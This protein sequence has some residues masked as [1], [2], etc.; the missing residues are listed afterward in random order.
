MTDTIPAPILSPPE[1]VSE[2]RT[3]LFADVRGYTRFTQEQGDEAAAALVKKFA[4]LMR[5]GVRAR[6]GRVIELRGDE[7][8]AIFGSARQALR[9][10]VDL[11]ARFAE[12]SLVNPSLP[13]PVGIGID[14]GEAIPV[15]GGYRGEALNLAARL[16]N[17]AGPGE[18]LASEGVVYLGRRVQGVSYAERGLVPL[19]GFA[20]PVRVIRIV[21]EAE[22]L[23]A[24]VAAEAIL[25]RSDASRQP[26]D[27]LPIGGFLGALPSGVLVGRE[28]EWD[29]V[30]GALES[31]MQGTGSLVLLSG[32]PGIGKTRMAQEVT[33]KA[34]HWNFLIA[35][36]RS[37]EPEQAV[38]YY[39]FLEAL[40]TLY[41]ACPTDIRLDVPRRWPYLARLLHDEIGLVPSPAGSENGGPSPLGRAETAT[42][43]E[44]QQRLFRSVTG[45][46]QA[47]AERIPIALLLDDLHWADDSSLKL[48]QHLA[49]Y[50]RGDR[51]FLLG[52][53]RDVEL[54]RQHPLEMALLDLGR[55]GLVEDVEVRRL[56]QEGTADLMA[57][58]VGE[59]EDLSD[60]AEI[61]YRN[62]EG[63]AFF[64]Q[65]VLRTLVDRGDFYRREDGR[66]ERRKVREMEVP[67]SIRSV[68]GQRLSRLEERAQEILREASVLGQTFIFDDLFA[69]TALAS[70]PGA[71][72]AGSSSDSGTGEGAIEAALE[73]AML[74]GLVR[75]AGDEV[76][77]FNHSLTQQALYA[78]L[79]TR[80]RKR[81]H[82]AAGQAL[83]RLP[84]RTR[85]RRTG[86][87]AY[88]FLEGD[89][90]ERALHYSMLAGDQA[91]A[92]FAN[93]EAAH[94]YQT[95]LDLARELG[96]PA[97]EIEVLEKLARV[98]TIVARYDRALA[99][100]DDAVRLYARQG[101]AEGEARVI[102]QIGHLH[103]LRGTPEEGIERLQPLLEA[104]E[105][106]EPSYGLAALWTALARLY[107][108]TER[109]AD[110]LEAAE[111]AMQMAEAIGDRPD[112]M[113]LQLNAEVT[114][115]DALW[116]LGH[117]DE[118]L[119]AM[120]EL[121]PRVEAA[122]DLDTLARALGNTADYYAKRGELEKDRLYH[123][124]ALEV[125]ERRGD[126]GYI[127]LWS[128]ALSSNAFLVGDWSAAR[129]Y[130][131]RAES[132]VRPLNNYRLAIWPMAAH[133]WLS[134]RQ[135]DLEVATHYAQE[136]LQRAPS[137][138]SLWRR[139]ARRLLA[140]IELA[141]GNASAALD[142]L[143][144]SL[145]AGGWE[146]DAAFLRNLAMV[147]LA[148][149]EKDDARRYAD[150]AV[151]QARAVNDQPELVEALIVQ[152]EVL[153]I[154][155]DQDALTSLTE[156]LAISRGMPF[157]YGEA[158]A[159]YE[160]AL[161]ADPVSSG[162]EGSERNRML[163]E[164]LL[165]F[166]RLGARLDI[167]RTRSALDL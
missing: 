115:A 150:K 135:G 10:A 16:C 47:I 58:I 42:A 77:A 102:A 162:Q 43:G 63:N 106:S 129:S 144:P 101:D 31:V 12:E 70:G 152:G 145:E 75:E 130:L 164:A 68:I 95:A 81:L 34:R 108:G 149:G 87:L 38:P 141:K 84:E 14:A 33:L 74:A 32:E 28:A 137:T 93:G 24:A 147:Y 91:E 161:L 157:P 166:E 67:K 86:E 54:H 29:R 92:V 83:E 21:R 128:L 6:G 44:D 30:M 167:E 119:H 127:V 96:D 107:L 142:Y 122:G 126:R 104:R 36:G 94:H 46:L 85:E 48:L 140:E 53:Y 132:I 37:Y 143:K 117:T 156:A 110:Q 136:A 66:W 69:L 97:C 76:Y 40:L 78:E 50:T 154:E 160:L 116:A 89:D 90:A 138:E 15:E 27:S 7:A 163:E 125:S 17:L 103:Y 57:E 121:I 65:E 59:K 13:L 51:V 61:V 56:D 39:P 80:R 79:S 109:Y 123:E 112:A 131:E 105:G 153:R 159:L 100:L 35:T 155:G 124:R 133:G 23:E 9:A 2:L 26:E 11:Q 45:F 18:V 88:H 25:G 113:R 99:L 148:L 8:L 120:E 64:I 72:N 139:Q 19:K 5:E 73:Q 158:Q 55:E 114:W 3:F 1:P 71:G 82:L 146:H 118:T 62:T 20:D 60:L 41:H 22:A 52:T 134:L 4:G 98:L 49:R 151:A 111:R 165:T